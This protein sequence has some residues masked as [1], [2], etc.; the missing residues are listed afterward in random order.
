[1]VDDAVVCVGGDG[2]GDAG[3]VAAGARSAGERSG[4]AASA[5]SVRVL[6][7]RHAGA[8]VSRAVPGVREVGG[9]GG[10]VPLKRE[11]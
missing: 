9:V 2:A 8:G 5:G 1:M 4:G 3:G 6:R 10:R 11:A 7:V